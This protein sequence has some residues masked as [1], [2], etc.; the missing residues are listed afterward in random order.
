L[1]DHLFKVSL[2]PTELDYLKKILELMRL[3]DSCY[4]NQKDTK[5]KIVRSNN[6]KKTIFNLITERCPFTFRTGRHSITIG[7]YISVGIYIEDEYTSLQLPSFEA[8]YKKCYE[9]LITHV[10]KTLDIKP[11]D[12]TDLH[13]KTLEM[14]NY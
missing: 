2:R 13:F 9:K 3:S 10:S 11:E 5:I 14:S 7:A 8:A 4:P 6:S 1:L 12:V